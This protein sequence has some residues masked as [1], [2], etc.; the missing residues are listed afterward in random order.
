M[1][2]KMAERA[3]ARVEKWLRSGCSGFSVLEKLSTPAL[4]QKLALRL[5]L[6][7]MPCS[8]SRF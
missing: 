1:Q 6:K 3:A 2:T 7:T 5:V 4:S 8:A